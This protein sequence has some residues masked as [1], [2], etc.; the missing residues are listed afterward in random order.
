[1][2]NDTNAASVLRFATNAAVIATESYMRTTGEHPFNCGFA[3][4]T[5]KP[6]R[7]ALVKELKRQGIGH[8][9]TY[10]GWQVWNPSGNMTQDC[11]AKAAGAMAFAKVLGDHNVNAI[12][13]SRLD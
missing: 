6:A 11:S 10:G 2:I 12:A 7:G 4:V 1:M 8:K 3:W 13:G 5:I 9:G